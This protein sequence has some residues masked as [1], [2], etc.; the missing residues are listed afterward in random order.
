MTNEDIINQVLDTEGGENAVII[1]SFNKCYVGTT[2][3]KPVRVVYDYWKC[4]DHLVNIE[5]WNF[6]ESVDYM[7]DLANV[8]LGEN[9]P[10]YVKQL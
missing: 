8:E 6:D 2:I 4:L 9:T 5:G 1:R 3:T 7:D 10:L